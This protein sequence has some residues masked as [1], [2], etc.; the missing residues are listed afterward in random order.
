[1]RRIK[2]TGALK[3]SVKAFNQTLFLNRDEDDFV[4][5][6]DRLDKLKTAIALDQTDYKC[7]LNKMLNYISHIEDNYF[8]ILDAD[9]AEMTVL[10]NEFDQILASNLVQKDKKFWNAVVSAMCYDQ[11]R[12]KEMLPFLH[13]LGIKTCIYCHSQLTV[14]VVKEK[15][16][17]NNVGR[18]IKRGDIKS[19][20]GL[21]TLDHRHAKSKYPF[22][23]TSFFNL[24]PACA[25]CN[26]SKNDNPCDFVL[27]CDDDDLDA[28][29][30]KL[31]NKSVIDYWLKNDQSLLEIEVVAKGLQPT[32]TF[33]K[34]YEEMFDVQK[35]YTTQLDVVEELVH[36][37]KVYTNTYNLQLIRSF[38]KLFPDQGF[39][40]RLIIGNYDRPED[41]HKRPMAKFVQEIARDLD[42]IT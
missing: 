37:A 23:A 33:K 13:E 32:T 25:N 24:Y 38:T 14:T 40:N 1:M 4:M 3:A 10:I 22:L 2:Y 15:Y 11:L 30:F 41:M 17:N 7:N 16:S 5:P 29:A 12:D 18:G 34:D 27:Y 8:R 28:F 9:G 31:T 39:L 35:I 20:R 6:M 36:K 26:Q 42:L 21:L 19:W